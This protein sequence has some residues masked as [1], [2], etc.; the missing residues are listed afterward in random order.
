MI[1]SLRTCNTSSGKISG[2]GFASAKIIGLARIVATIAGLSTPAADSPRKMSAPSITSPSVRAEVGCAN[3]I[4]SASI[5]S[6]R[7]SKTTPARSVTQ[8]FSRGRPSL[9]SRPRQASAAAPA[10]ETTSLTSRMSLPL[11]FNPFSTAAPTTIAV[12]C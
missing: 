10:P 9:T 12:P 2:V 8:M 1:A 5:S 4:L 11:T 7:P 6:V 3:T